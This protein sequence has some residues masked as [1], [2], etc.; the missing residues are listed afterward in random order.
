MSLLDVNE[1]VKFAVRI[2]ENGEAFYRDWAKKAA[3]QKQKD[4]FSH[5]ADEEVKHKQIFA[6]MLNKTKNY[7]MEMEAYGNYMGYLKNYA[8]DVLFSAENL[9]KKMA[10]IHHFADALDFAIGRELESIFF[11]QEL[12]NFIPGPQ[13][14]IINQIIKEERKH[15]AELNKIKAEL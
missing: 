8:D 5:L 15:F 14:E 1:L 12:K 13:E 7:P 9:K 6:D 2:E 11:Y 10:A 4:L 3:D